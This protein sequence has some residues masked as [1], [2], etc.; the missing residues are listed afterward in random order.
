VKTAFLTQPEICGGYSFSA[1]ALPYPEQR[2][3]GLRVSEDP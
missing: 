3:D 2:E 1:L